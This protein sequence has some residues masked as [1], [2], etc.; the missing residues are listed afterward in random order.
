MTEEPR[1]EDALDEAL[2]RLARKGPEYGGGLSNHGPMAA[3]AL[4]ALGRAE[5][6]QPWTDD[7]LTQV[8]E[9]LVQGRALPR[10]EWAS[11]LGDFDRFADWVAL[12]ERELADAPWRDVLT[13]WIPRLAPGLVGAA[14]HGLIRAAHAVRGLGHRES[15]IRTTELA[16]GLAYW[17]A[18][19]QRLP[20]TQAG[21]QGHLLPSEALTS[22]PLNREPPQ[23]NALISS[24]LEALGGSTDFAGVAHLVDA[25][26]EPSAFLSD[27][28]RS[29]AA[30]FLRDSGPD[31]LIALVHGLT[32]PSAARLLGP[33]LAPRDRA[34][35]LRYAWQAGAALYS[36]FGRPMRHVELP[37]ELPAREN[38]VDRAVATGDEHA[39]KFTEACLRED[40]ID[41]HPIFRHAAAK[42]TDQFAV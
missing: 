32:A 9:F 17:A 18:R 7:Y 23:E 5:S 31:T 35:T 39:I 37:E 26:I 20:E 33:Y 3:E 6:V 1:N 14:G 36:R 13:L 24:E 27:M 21:A 11:G 30:V 19:F 15:R 8:D 29:L 34:V 12:F 4:V 2:E 22:V 28:A 38:L 42:A 10:S 25:S 40:A 16:Q 41:P